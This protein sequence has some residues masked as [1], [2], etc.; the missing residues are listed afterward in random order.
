[1]ATGGIT[2]GKSHKEG[3][4]PMKVKS[5]G[6]NIEVEGGEI[7]INKKSVSDTKKNNFNGKQLT[8][9]EIASEINSDNNNGVEIDCDDVVGKSY[10]AKGG[11]VNIDYFEEYELLEN[12]YP[13]IYDVVF[14]QG[15]LTDYKDTEKLL[16]KLNSMGW[17]FDYGLDNSPY[18]L[19]P[20]K[21]KEEL[22]FLMRNDPYIN[23]FEEFYEKGGGIGTPIKYQGTKDGYKPD[24][25]FLRLLNTPKNISR[26]VYS[27][28]IIPKPLKNLSIDPEN[29]SF[30][31]VCDLY[32]GTD[33]LR[34]IMQLVNYDKELGTICCTDAHKLF[35][36]QPKPFP[37][38]NG[39]Y[40]TPKAYSKV[41][42]DER[43]KMLG[44]QE[45]AGKYPNYVAVIPKTDLNTIENIDTEKLY[46]FC[47]ILNNWR[48]EEISSANKLVKYK[49]LGTYTSNII[50]KYKNSENEDIFCGVNANF[51]SSCLKGMFML[52]S[53]NLGYNVNKVT[54]QNKRNNNGLLFNYSGK[55]KDTNN[56]INSNFNGF[57]LMPTIL[58][59][60]MHIGSLD[61]E[62]QLSIIYDLDS[63]TILSNGKNFDI[64]EELG[65]KGLTKKVVT[66]NKKIVKQ[67]NDIDY[68]NEKIDAIKIVLKYEPKNAYA[69]QE[70]EALKVLKKYTPKKANAGLLLAQQ[71]LSDPK[72]RKDVLDM[73]KANKSMRPNY[74]KGG[75]VIEGVRFGKES[76]DLEDYLDNNS[77]EVIEKD[78]GDKGTKFTLSMKDVEYEQRVDLEDY[79]D[80]NN[81]KYIDSYAKGGSTKSNNSQVA[82][83]IIKQLG[84]IGK[85]KAFTGAYAFGTNGNNVTFRIKNRKVNAI[86]ITLNGNDLYDIKFFRIRGADL[87]II[88]EYTDIYND[89]L[90][91]LFEENTGMYLS[92]EK[93][94]DIDSFAK[95]I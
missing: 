68:I 16:N 8:N 36:I 90:I 34:P 7:I 26:K 72:A 93:G 35:N 15:E 59:G 56:Y 64:N 25:D 85:L 22:K 9:C 52:G 13:K 83:T 23:E 91:S 49:F 66:E 50:L 88:K 37:N 3:G 40:N 92:F 51:L 31:K 48:I 79:L 44:V 61:F 94:G 43:E 27:K 62:Y 46:W 30:G 19:R 73:L 95:R 21:D 87:K 47:T 54:L 10:Y 81:L 11:K 63:N 42:G 1:M 84:G 2:E 76:K 74:A 14:E 58:D 12:E 24:N 38:F 32:R 71:V 53:D 39:L 77:W 69:K 57:L 6:Q 41:Y 67:D 60:E 89:Q 80:N 17:T 45:Y 5:T 55:I 65:F 75:L 29:A 18:D 28:A 82:E 78:S 4:I 33:D 20:M 70:L 86:T